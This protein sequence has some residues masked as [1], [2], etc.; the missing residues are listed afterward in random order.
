MT[1]EREREKK[2]EGRR[3]R[4]NTQTQNY[5]QINIDGRMN[6]FIVNQDKKV[7]SFPEVDLEENERDA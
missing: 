7:Q 3:P 1:I 4:K 2:E 5:V 6:S